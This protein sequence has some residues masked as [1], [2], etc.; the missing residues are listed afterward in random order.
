MRRAACGPTR[1][2]RQQQAAARLSAYV[3]HGVFPRESWNKFKADDGNGAAA[4]GGFR[5]FWLSDSCPQ[6]TAAVK[7][8][9]P[10]EVLTL[11]GPIAAALQI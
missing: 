6:T 4:N 7:G 1:K 3:T 9:Q 11:A 5:F 8:R 10:F 2:S